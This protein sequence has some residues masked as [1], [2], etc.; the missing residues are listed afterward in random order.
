M[1]Q[2]DSKLGTLVLFMWIG[3]I[4]LSI[5]SG[6]LAWDLIEPDNFL[7]AIGFLI[8]WGILSKIGHYIMFG[9]IYLLFD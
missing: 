2:D 7:G 9:V 5:L 3:T 4:A 1:G 8:V 6:I